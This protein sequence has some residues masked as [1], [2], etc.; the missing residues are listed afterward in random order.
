[1][2]TIEQKLQAVLDSKNAIKEALESLG[3]SPT[4][5]FSTYADIIR[6]LS[7][8]TPE[9]K[10]YELTA[11]NIPVYV[12]GAA[13]NGNLIV[14]I[15][16]NDVVIYSADNGV[17]W[18][19]YTIDKGLTYQDMTY[20]KGVF[21]V[22]SAETDVV[23]YSTDGLIW[24]EA[25]IGYTGDWRSVAYGNGTFVAVCANTAQ[26]AV[27][28]N[29]ISWHL[30]NLP[31]SQEWT[32]IKWCKDRFMAVAKGSTDGAYSFDGLTWE[33]FT[34]PS[35]SSWCDI[36][37]GNGRCIAISGGTSGTTAS[38][39]A[40]TED[41]DGTWVKGTM[42]IAAN[43]RNIC[44]VSGVWI[45]TSKTGYVHYSFDGLEWTYEN[46]TTT[47]GLVHI[48]YINGYF[49][50]LPSANSAQ[51]AVLIKI[52][53][54]DADMAYLGDALPEDVACGVTFSSI[55]G[56]GLVGTKP[57]DETE[58][59]ILNTGDGTQIAMASVLS[60]E[61][62]VATATENDIRSG[63]TAYTERGYTEGTKDIPAYHTTTGYR[64]VPANTEFKIPLLDGDNYD[65]TKFQAMIMPWNTT[66]EDSVAVDRVV[67]EDKVYM[68]GSTE[69][70]STV[71]KDDENKSILLG[72]T[73]GE[74]PMVI[75][76]F[77]YKEVP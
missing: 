37:Y 29:G 72:L 40:Y 31:A 63:T 76:Y 15:T 28:A 36:E 66:L 19:Q 8:F 35:A 1:M 10:S 59:Y 56:Y 48:V 60:E 4:E 55:H 12:A 61:N 54:P 11:S 67:I 71:T 39:Y 46:I 68:A 75:R 34:L 73:N 5:V 32:A 22:V 43:Y 26:A 2:G 77:T 38:G 16:T 69:V 9:I 14:A 33:T 13:A 18:N 49:V 30:V 21:V 3:M 44:Y 42:P 58:V 6:N 64:I 25:T 53:T 47:T 52:K 45:M 7:S 17:T 41:L 51:K 62:T 24:N 57:V 74:T 65:Y 20:G 27:S 50:L 70:V 23:L